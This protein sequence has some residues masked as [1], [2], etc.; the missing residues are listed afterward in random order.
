M[1]DVPRFR[2]LAEDT[3]FH[4]F[5]LSNQVMVNGPYREQRGDVDKLSA[6]APVT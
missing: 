4:P 3:C 2:R 6:G 5:P 1:M